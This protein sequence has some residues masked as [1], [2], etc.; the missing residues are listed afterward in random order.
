MLGICGSAATNHIAFSLVPQD[1]AEL[2]G[3]IDAPS[4]GDGRGGASDSAAIG[5]AGEARAVATIAK[6]M[7]CLEMRQ[8]AL[9]FS[10]AI[11]H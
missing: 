8:A 10:K 4:L 2:A 11:S 9:R 1:A 6:P 5:G 7:K 3:R